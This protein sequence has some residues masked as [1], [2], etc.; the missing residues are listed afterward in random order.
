MN[1]ITQYKPKQFWDRPEGTTGM[2][3][4]ALLSVGG[5]FVA[6]AWLP[7]ILDVLTMGISAVGK[8]IT[9]TLGG[10]VLFSLLYIL[11]NKSFQTARASRQF[12]S[13]LMR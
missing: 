12:R 4:I 5:F 7:A 13:N 3:T 1:N 9:L 11:T 8:A 2:I 6:R 10:T